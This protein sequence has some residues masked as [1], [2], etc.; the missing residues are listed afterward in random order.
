M[1]CWLD[2]FAVEQTL[3]LMNDFNISVFVETGTFKGC[4][5]ELYSNY[6]DY[7]VTCDINEEYCKVAKERMKNKD[8]VSV[9]LD[10]S[11]NVL[12]KIVNAHKEEKSQENVFFFLDAH[13]YNKDAKSDED[14]WV[15]IKELKAMKDFNHAIIA[16]HDFDCNNLGHIKYDGESFDWSIVS[17]HLQE[18]NPNFSYYCNTKEFCDPRNLDRVREI[19]VTIN[20]DTIDM[21]NYA[22]QS[23]EKKYRGILYA[24]PKKLDLTK[25]KLVEFNNV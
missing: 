11:Y 20:D 16:I 17:K 2:K 5:A 25:Y 23:D 10:N 14:K 1:P 13:I 15:I 24:V 9:V 3:K 6:F 18:V 4:G 21:V 19:P 7:V 12:L 8:N 22:N